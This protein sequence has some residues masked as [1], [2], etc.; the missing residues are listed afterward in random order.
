MCNPRVARPSFE[1]WRDFLR[2][3]P[4]VDVARADPEGPEQP[5]LMAGA[6]GEALQT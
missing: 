4:L 1:R 5:V 6:S 3:G 2:S